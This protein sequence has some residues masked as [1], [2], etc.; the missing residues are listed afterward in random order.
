LRF[1]ID[2]D[3]KPVLG[4]FTKSSLF[5]SDADQEGRKRNTDE[6]EEEVEGERKEP[7]ISPELANNPI[8]KVLGKENILLMIS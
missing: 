6:M 5:G 1:D 3:K 7:E 2:T 8:F 4:I